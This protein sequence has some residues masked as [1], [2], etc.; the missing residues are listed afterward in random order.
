[1]NKFLK[2]IC[3]FTMIVKIMDISAYTP[4]ENHGHRNTASGAIAQEGVT[5]AMNGVPF[6]TKV[7][8]R[9]HEYTVQDRLASHFSHR[10]DIFMED[11][12]R[13]I[14]FGV[15]RGERVEIIMN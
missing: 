14:Q 7:I 12:N 5:C 10:I 8:F 2:A 3:L 9:G 6:G 1:L 13:A 15:K 11:Y 4:H